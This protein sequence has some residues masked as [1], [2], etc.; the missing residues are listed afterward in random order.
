MYDL[1]P[2]PFTVDHAADEV[3]AIGLIKT[4][5]AL[6]TIAKVRNPEHADD[7]F[8]AYPDATYT[9]DTGVIAF[10]GDTYETVA[11]AARAA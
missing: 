5:A 6:F 9:N 7:S 2:D 8:R 11:A 4:D 10:S 3:F 1:M